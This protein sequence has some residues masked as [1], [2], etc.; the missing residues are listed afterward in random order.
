[1]SSSAD[2]NLLYG[3]LALQLDFI[4]R[5]ALVAAMNSWLLRKELSIGQ[6]LLEQGAVDQQHH[7]LIDALVLAH[8]KQHGE[9][10]ERSLAALSSLGSIRDA[11]EAVSDRELQDSL[12]R[13]PTHPS[14]ASIQTMAMNMLEPKPTESRFRILRQHAKG[15]LGEVHVALDVELHREVALKE[16]QKRHADDPESRTRFLMEAQITGGLE[17]P[18]IVPVYGLG[19][20]IDGRPFYAMRFI[21]GD[22]LREAIDRF[23]RAD[24]PD[25]DPGERTLEFHKLLGRF[26]DVC[27]AMQYAHDRGILHRDLKPGNIML[28]RYGETL[29]VDWGLAKPIGKS[30]SSEGSDEPTLRLESASSS[31]ET[32]AGTALGTPQYMS[33]EQ[34]EGRLDRLGTASDV[35]S[36]GATLYCLLTGRAPFELEEVGEILR[37]VQRGLFPPPRKIQSRIPRNLEAV[38]LKAMALR[39]ED[40]YASPGALAEDIKN[41]LANEPVSAWPEPWSWRVAR[42]GRR[43]RAV[44]EGLVCLVAAGLL[45][46]VFATAWQREQARQ[47]R[48]ARRVAERHHENGLRIAASFAAR[49]IAYEVDLRWWILRGAAEDAELRRLVVSLENEPSL[50]DA[51]TRSELQAWIDHRFAESRRTKATSWFITDRRG[52]QLARHPPSYDLIGKSF[53]FR[54]YF[55]GEGRDYPPETIKKPIDNVYRSLVFE[56]QATGNRAVAFT[57]PVWEGLPRESECLGVLGMTVELGTFGG[58]NVESAAA[59]PTGVRDRFAVLV[60]LRMDALESPEKNGLIL[61]HPGLDGVRTRS[62]EKHPVM[63]LKA[64]QI[65]RLEQLRIAA[66]KPEGKTKDLSLD[67]NYDDP[68]GGEYA[69]RWLAAFAPVI[70]EERSARL[71]DTGWAV[72]VQDR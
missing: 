65:E 8:L 33:P 2:R 15:G 69:G 50:V 48:R 71:R 25:R 51:P 29:V 44:V 40:R 32:V 62:G 23:H 55:H 18:G 28:G 68:I 19:Q 3:V 63:R 53:A 22:S 36:L 7:D 46:M 37:K 61:Q 30:E 43:H 12:C 5:D 38:C 58:L 41:W 64:A 24:A 27:D 16:I 26:V 47:E 21:R 1:M 14:P 42:W 57:V 54:D 20:Y 66:N 34:A 6:I 60:D 59:T 10:A 35:Y 9:C 17:H 49:T 39:R 56:S 31:A 4:K 72:I 11:L 52:R 70:I 13:I 45:A 67:R